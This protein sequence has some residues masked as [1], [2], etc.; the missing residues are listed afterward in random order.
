VATA[1]VYVLAAHAV[2]TPKLL[3][4]SATDS[5]PQGVANSSDQV[6]RNLMDHPVQLNYALHTQPLYPFRG[7]LSTSGIESLR[8]GPFRKTRAAFRVEIGNE[9]WNWATGDPY[10]TVN[11]LVSPGLNTLTG[12]TKVQ[13]GL[14][15]DKLREQVNAIVTHQFRFGAVVEQMPLSTNR[16]VPSKTYVDNLNIPRPEITYDLDDYTKAGIAAASRA[17]TAIFNKLGATEY[18]YVN[19]DDPSTFQFT[20]PATGETNTYMLYGAGHL[21]GTYRMGTDAGSSVVDAD[22]RSHDHQNLFMLGSGVFPAVGTA[23]PTLTIA[24]MSLRAADA[25]LAD[26][27]KGTV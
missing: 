23:N 16:I 25:I 9:G 11:A 1:T 27:N 3:L 4:N 17:A 19:P 18:T 8:D 13:G 24:A 2:E 14:F 21:M 20:D 26:L 7:P 6:G 22:L 12:P 5:L 10:T 15:G